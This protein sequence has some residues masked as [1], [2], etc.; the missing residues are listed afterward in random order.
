MKNIAIIPARSGSKGLK[1]KNIKL[2]NGKPLLAYS[3]EAALESKMFDEVMVSTDSEKYAAIAREYGANVPFLRSAE[4]SSDTASS[5]DVI[6]DVLRRYEASGMIFDTFCLLQPTSPLRTA[7]DIIN[8]YEYFAEKAAL[9]V[10]G[11]TEADHSPLLYG[12]LPEDRSL[13]GFIKDEVKDKPRQ[14]LETYYRINGAMYIASVGY[15]REFGDFFKDRCYAYVMERE[16]SV[17][18][19]SEMDFKLSEIIIGKG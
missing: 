16:V 13:V 12:T 18:I 3:V 6:L 19:D 14:A 4:L 10:V 8:A 7:S 1:D 5:K 15:Y 2:L 17:D 9:A 11:V